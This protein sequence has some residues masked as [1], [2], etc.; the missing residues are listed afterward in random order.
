M[1]DPLIS[2]EFKY[3]NTDLENEWSDYVNRFALKNKGERV[4]AL[5]KCD[6]W[7]ALDARPTKE[8]ASMWQRKRQLEHLHWRLDALGR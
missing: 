1:E 8:F 5:H 6:E 7:L 3:F 4:N 2:Q